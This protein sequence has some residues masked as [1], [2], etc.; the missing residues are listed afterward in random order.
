MI[1]NAILFTLSLLFILFVGSTQ[2]ASGEQ[3]A[4]VNIED[5]TFEDSI[6]ALRNIYNI[7]ITL[8]GIKDFSKK[9]FSL[10]LEHATFNEAV[11]VAMHRADVQSY[12]IVVNQQKQTAHIWILD[13]GTIL[14]VSNS[15]QG[16]H[17]KSMTAQEFMTLEPGESENF[18]MMTE[19]EFE[20]LEAESEENFKGI[21]PEEFAGLEPTESENFRM[22]TE[23]EFERLE[24]E[25]EEN[26][27]GI[28]SEEFAQLRQH[29]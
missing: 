9:E 10:K 24:A 11:R 16:Q 4:S 28:T 21:T 26:F 15:I 12:A 18:R 22:M 23:E 13:A 27:K 7:E 2:V 6:R 29:Q 1:N 20:R 8:I 25:S 14:S 3:R 17:M 19:E 5:T